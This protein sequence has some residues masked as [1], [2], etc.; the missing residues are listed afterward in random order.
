MSNRIPVLSGILAITLGVLVAVVRR[1]MS[2][3]QR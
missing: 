2:P 3:I 1:D